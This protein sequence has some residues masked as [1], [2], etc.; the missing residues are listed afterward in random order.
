MGGGVTPKRG[1]GLLMKNLLGLMM[2]GWASSA[3]AADVD[4]LFAEGDYAQIIIQGPITEGDAVDFYD[5]AELYPRA[6]VA[7]DSPG[8]NVMEALSI[9]S[10]IRLR[11]FTTFVAGGEMQC[12]SACALI[13][14]AGVRRYMAPAS[15]IGVHAA[16]KM[17]VD[18][19]GAEKARES[20]VGNAQI[21]AYLNGLG[22]SAKAISFFT[23]AAPNEFK[24]IT[25]SAAQ[26]FDIDVYVQDEAGFQTPEERPTP[27]RIANKATQLL[28]AATWCPPILNLRSEPIETQ[29][30]DVLREGH[31]IFGGE[32]FGS[33]I[34][35]Y[36]DRRLAERE[37]MGNPAWC[38]ATI[39]TLM[40]AGVQIAGLSGPSFNCNRASTASERTIC[41]HPELWTRDRLL[42]SA[43][44]Y[45]RQI[46]SSND[47]ARVQRNQASWLQRR[48]ECGA[49][50]DC[51]MRSYDSRLWEMGLVGN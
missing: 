22:L 30:G 2:I 26:V 28:S 3:A 33:L 38:I 45:F 24:Y 9:G 6:S 12:Y 36:M 21:G 35:E 20:G 32:I 7:L 34:V 29:G 19:D 17:V 47:F 4:V 49:D 43:Y 18:N 37:R 42:A 25:P 10:E 40:D 23:V 15:Q 46:M 48:R 14:I 31:E 16:Y 41:K 44:E 27:R 13:W 8:G 50:K 5:L 11:G 51:N 1:N 39:D